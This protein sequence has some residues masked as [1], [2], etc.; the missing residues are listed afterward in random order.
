[1]HAIAKLLFLFILLAAPTHAIGQD[2]SSWLVDTLYGSGKMN[3]VLVV[4]GVILLG[5]FFWLFRLD[6]RIARMEKEQGK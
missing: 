4:V 6:R 2:G 1:M 5:L 3:T